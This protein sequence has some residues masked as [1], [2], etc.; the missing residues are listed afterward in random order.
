MSI[1]SVSP[2]FT[3]VLSLPALG[4]DTGTYEVAGQIPAG[5]HRWQTSDLLDAL[6]TRVAL[7][8]A[9]RELAVYYYRINHT[10]AFPLPL[11]Q[12]PPEMPAGIPGR[13]SYP[14]LTWLLWVLEERWRV[15]HAAWRQLDDQEAGTLLQTELAA[16]A[17]W[18]SF[19][20][21]N[22][23]VGLAA[24]HTA[25]CLTQALATR[26]GWNAD[27]YQQV[28]EVAA[29]LIERDVWPW[30]QSVWTMEEALRPH[31]IHNIPVIALVR[32]AGLAR[33]IE[34]PRAA[35]LEE[36]ATETLRAW[37][38]H[39]LDA[40]Q[41]H[42]EGT[43]YDG[44][45]MDT[46]TEWLEGLAN[47]KML[48]A[49]GREAF[50]SLARQ[51]IHLTLPG[52]L[53]LHAPLSDVEPEMPFWMT[54]LLR[55]GLWYG[56]AESLWLL[57]HLPLARL[58]AAS[59]AAAWANR[60]RLAADFSP[61]QPGPQEEASAATLRT[62]WDSQDV[63]VAVGLSRSP[64]SHLHDDGGHVLIGW[65]NRFWITDPGYQQYRPGPERSFTLDAEAHNAPV[66]D[67]V[68]QTKRAARRIRIADN[69]S[70]WQ[71]LRLELT[72]C[73]ADLPAAAR[74]YRDVWLIPEAGHGS[75]LAVVR[76]TFHGLAPGTEIQN[77]WQGG[78]HLAWAFRAGWARLSDGERT[79]W[80]GTV[81]GSAQAA[82]LERHGGSRGPLTL[83]HGSRLTAERE[84]RWWI[85]QMDPILGWEPPQVAVMADR[86]A[87]AVSK[88]GDAQAVEPPLQIE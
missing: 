18:N 39:R 25:A 7:E 15:L 62:G 58:P 79:L 30:Y 77:H 87:L 11:D 10:M 2:P 29:T 52:R 55:I 75:H 17:G 45:L 70:G 88:A 56:H 48:L 32:S 47:R 22:G 60:E 46:F 51:W 86:P 16:L 71:Q 23:Q 42:S 80:I 83:H 84:E 54:A 41:P 19:A 64:M 9:R 57:Q 69:G 12:R 28:Q 40:D 76:D 36:R 53:D 33:L 6:K 1:A 59:L 26:S 66:I 38:R 50:L 37:W 68:Y 8:K 74:I 73:Y 13:P 72:D 5:L 81:P 21:W 67:G 85:F 14:W 82:G 35:A 65:Q 44:Y 63:L 78:T 61:P 43:A 49:E 4:Y 24:G 34:H 3:P 27:R 31:D 20:G